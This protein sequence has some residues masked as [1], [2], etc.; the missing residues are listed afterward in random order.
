MLT[1]YPRLPM[2]MGRFLL[3]GL[4]FERWGFLWVLVVLTAPGWFRREGALPG[5]YLAGMLLVFTAAVTLS[6]LHV[7]YQLATACSRLVSQLAPLA[8]ACVGLG[9]VHPAKTGSSNRAMPS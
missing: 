9:I 5:I 1:H 2:V 4:H 3:E 6:P 7:E 8:A